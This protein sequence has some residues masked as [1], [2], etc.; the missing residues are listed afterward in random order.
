MKYLLAVIIVATIFFYPKSYFIWRPAEG[1]QLN[2]QCLGMDRGNAKR[3][4]S[5][6]PA[7][8]KICLGMP[9]SCDTR[10][11]SWIEYVKSDWSL[12]YLL[13]AEVV[14]VLAYRAASKRA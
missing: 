2:C 5:K 7:S 12:I 14:L 9:V 13:A 11:I 1:L 6:N 3:E 8:R 4:W 10:K